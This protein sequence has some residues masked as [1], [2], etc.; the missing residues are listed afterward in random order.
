MSEIQIRNIVDRLTSS[1]ETSGTDGSDSTT[2]NGKT[3]SKLSREAMTLGE[4][5]EQELTAAIYKVFDENAGQDKVFPEKNRPPKILNEYK[6]KPYEYELRDEYANGSLPLPSVKAF[7][8]AGKPATAKIIRDFIKST[9]V[10]RPART[11]GASRALS[12]YR[13]LTRGNPR[14]PRITDSG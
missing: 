3:I 1:D 7:N 11:T 13:S 4:K 5:V 2:I 10:S 6:D 14:I 8:W 9:P 12:L